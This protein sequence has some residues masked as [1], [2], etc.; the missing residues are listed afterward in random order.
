MESLAVVKAGMSSE[1]LFRRATESALA[2]ESAR[3]VE[4]ITA[5]MESDTATVS[6]TFSV[7]SE[8][9]RILFLLDRLSS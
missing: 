3:A 2:T 9:S 8:R 1:L 7:L 4:S 6:A 5:L